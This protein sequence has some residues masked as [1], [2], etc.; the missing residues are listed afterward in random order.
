VSAV[1]D[2]IRVVVVEDHAMF[3]QA[4]TMLLEQDARVMLVGS[5][6]DAEHGIE[7][8]VA[9]RADVVVMDIGMPGID[10]IEATRRLQL[11]RPE[12]AVVVLSGTG[13]LADAARAAGAAAYL[14]KGGVHEEVADAIVSA[15]RDH[16]DHLAGRDRLT[17]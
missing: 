11:V 2:P 5:A 1:P 15:A 17:D 4:L 14:M 10:G 6:S 16:A 8:A 9:D 13:D 3:S 7:L 12:S